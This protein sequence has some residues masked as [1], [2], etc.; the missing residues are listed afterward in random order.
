MNDEELQPGENIRCEINPKD[1]TCTLLITGATPTMQG[2]IKAVAK[3]NGGEVLCSAKLD[4]RGRA[5]T[6]VEAPLKCTVLEGM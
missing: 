1:G 6:F 3:N 4:V 5:P 2:E